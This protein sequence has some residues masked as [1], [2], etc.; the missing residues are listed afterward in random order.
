MITDIISL[1]GRAAGKYFDTQEKADEFRADI[2]KLLS[3]NEAK[4]LQAQR[5]VVIAEIQGQDHIQR[6]WRPILMMVCIFIVF[7]NYVLAPYMNLFFLTDIALQLDDNI[8]ALMKIGV[9]G[10]TAG[11]S[12][13]KIA[14]LWKGFRA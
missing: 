6:L 3:D 4:I 13:E 12:A 11:R 1:V 9:G 5:D 2:S 7:N 8:W 14:G 10:Y